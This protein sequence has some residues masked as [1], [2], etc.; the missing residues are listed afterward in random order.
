MLNKNIFISSIILWTCCPAEMTILLGTSFIDASQKLL[1]PT[2]ELPSLACNPG[3]WKEES[4]H[5]ANQPEQEKERI[6]TQQKESLELKDISVEE[7]DRA[8]P[9]LGFGLA[10]SE[11]KRTEVFNILNAN[12]LLQPFH[13]ISCKEM[14][15]TTFFGKTFILKPKN[16]MGNPQYSAPEACAK[17]EVLAGKKI[18]QAFVNEISAI[19]SDNSEKSYEEIFKELSYLQYLVV[20]VDCGEYIASLEV[21]KA[22][23]LGEEIKNISTN[24]SI[25]S[26]ASSSPTNPNE[27]NGIP[28]PPNLFCKKVHRPKE[29]PKQLKKRIGMA[30]NLVK[31]INFLH[32]HG[33]IHNDIHWG[34]FLLKESDCCQAYLI[35][36]DQTVISADTEK[37]SGEI[38]RMRELLVEYLFLSTKCKG[39]NESWEDMIQKINFET[40]SL[41]YKEQQLKQINGL[42]SDLK[43]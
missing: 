32:R 7:I 34:N 41:L 10:A 13:G 31:I 9:Y 14:K 6:W 23:T 4:A 27:D 43:N 40:D 11:Q 20:P 18:R 36:F 38:E 26:S 24:T 39:H 1:I 8:F 28:M 19:K 37:I 42:F 33:I 17:R 21:P 5:H 12:P 25:S 16:K 29:S 22:Q 2:W 15:K 3:G 30:S 35:D